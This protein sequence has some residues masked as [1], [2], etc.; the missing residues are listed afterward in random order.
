[1]YG[2]S[3]Y[4]GTEPTREELDY[5]RADR[6]RA[7]QYSHQLEREALEAREAAKQER[8]AWAADYGEL[9]DELGELQERY[10][11]LD[12][13]ITPHLVGDLRGAAR[14]AQETGRSGFAEELRRWARRIEEALECDRYD[15][16]ADT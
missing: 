15:D 1:M 7:E 2:Y 16:S 10:S 12:S 14:I 13:T 3:F 9:L 5:A 8:L 6:D 11:R 4:R